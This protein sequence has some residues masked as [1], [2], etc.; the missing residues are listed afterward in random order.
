MGMRSTVEL[1]G[2]ELPVD[3]GMY[4]PEDVVPDAHFLDLII[5]IDTSYVLIK[6][7]E[8]AAVFDYDTLVGEIDTLARDGHYETQEWLIT[9]IACACAQ[10]DEIETIEVMVYKSPVLAGTGKLGVRL[11]IDHTELRQIVIGPSKK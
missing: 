4:A 8:M 11:T 2:L 1:T 9:W 6:T 5:T 10:Y 3:P 7:D